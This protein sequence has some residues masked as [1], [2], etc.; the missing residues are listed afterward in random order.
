MERAVFAIGGNAI[1]DP[2]DMSGTDVIKKVVNVI[3]ILVDRGYEI[4]ITHGNGPQVGFAL[5]RNELAQQELPLQSLDLI[6]AT[7]QGEIGYFIEKELRGTVSADVVTVITMVEVDV[8][9]KSFVNPTKFVGRTYPFEEKTRLEKEKGWILKEYRRGE[10]RRVVPSPKPKTIVQSE[11]IKEILSNK[12]LVICC[13]G[14]GI[15]VARKGEKLIGVEGVVDKDLSSSLLAKEIEAELLVIVTNVPA[16]FLGY[17][18][19]NEVAIDKISASE[20]KVYLDKGYFPPGSMG[21]K[22]EAAIFFVE[23]GGKR[24][25]ITD[26]NNLQAALEGRSGTIIVK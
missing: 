18:T 9:D 5:L 20:L 2:R 19:P 10:Y 23:N 13:G 6:V 8:D 11:V 22:I 7:T 3:H 21:P 15:P 26:H 12:F 16:V 17:G 14:G 1:V 24:A 4:A 25:I